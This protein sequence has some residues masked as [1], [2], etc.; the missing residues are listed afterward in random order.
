MVPQNRY[1]QRLQR[2]QRLLVAEDLDYLLVNAVPQLRYLVAYTG[3]NGLLVLGK[4]SAQFLTDGRYREQ[5]R[6]EVHGAKVQIVPG[7]LLA[8]LPQMP[9]LAKGRP[10]IG[11]ESSLY[12]EKAA[13]R[14]RSLAPCALFVPLE[15][16]VAPLLQVKDKQ[17]VACI[18]R[19][20]AIADFA[21]ASV[22]PLIKPGVRER[23]LAAELEYIMARAGSEQVPFE[24]I[25]ASGPRSALPHGRAGT[26][27]IAKGDFVTLDYG[28]TMGGYVSDITRTVVVGRATTRQRRVYQMVLRAQKAALARVRPGALCA[29]LDRA[30][31]SVIERSGDGRHFDHGLGHGIGL[32]VHEGPAVNAKSKVVL[33]SGM[34][35][36]IEPGVYY[37]GWGGVRIEDDVVVR[38]G[39]TTVLTSAERRLLEL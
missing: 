4:G 38:P 34:V 31:R 1:R 26:R 16:F 37:P 14:L 10:R 9:Q 13:L 20:A 29:D 6:H 17:E 2:V 5:A 23:D 27:R 32:V 21:F 11:Y 8:H 18:R 33:K 12:S 36:T 3:S 30:A 24:S 7:D 39:G 25:V 35:I 28:A 15:E 19:A 22:L